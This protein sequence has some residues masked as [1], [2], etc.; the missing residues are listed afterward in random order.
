[1]VFR[2]TEG[3]PSPLWKVA[4]STAGAWPPFWGNRGRSLLFTRLGL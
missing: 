1:M 3:A 2:W 4:L